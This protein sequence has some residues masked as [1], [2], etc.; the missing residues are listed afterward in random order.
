[1]II[2]YEYIHLCTFIRVLQVTLVQCS[3]AT[4]KGKDSRSSYRT[5]FGKLPYSNYFGYKSCSQ[6]CQ[7]SL[8]FHDVLSLIFSQYVTLEEIYNGCVKKMK[9]SRRV[10]QA[11]G[12]PKKEDK[13]V[14]I[15]VKPGWKS[16][17]KVTCK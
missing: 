13:Y 1:M 14:S 9:I 16:G 17:T 3:Y 7:N 8:T 4:Q 2:N 12:S 10:M 15:S 5:R 6:M 11:D